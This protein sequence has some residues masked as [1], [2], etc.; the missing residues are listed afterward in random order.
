MKTLKFRN[1]NEEVEVGKLVCVGRNY[2]K[3]AEEMGNEV[4]EF[5]LIFLKP[6]SSLISPEANIIHPE[7]STE[8]HHEVELVLY[9]GE[10]I[11]NADDRLAE[12]AI[13]G[14]AVGLDMTLRDVQ[15]NLKKKGHPWTIAKCFDTSAVISAIVEKSEYSLKGGERISLSVNDEEK[16]NSKLDTMI[17]SPVNVVKYISTIMTLEKGDLIY[18]GTPEGVG[19]V[20]RGDIISASIENI[21]EF[22]IN[23]L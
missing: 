1:S 19:Q 18:T 10:T 2:V 9:I 5:P 12:E 23:V 14:Y 8:M 17:F 4:P 20:N 21:A 16:Q 3:H 6:A 22:K 15:S 11:K 13:K 7:Y